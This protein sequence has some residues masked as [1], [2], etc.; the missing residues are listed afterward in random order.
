MHEVTHI[1]VAGKRLETAYVGDGDL[2]APTLVMLHEGLGCVG[3][4]KDFPQKAA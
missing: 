4:W 2:S 1:V 3:M